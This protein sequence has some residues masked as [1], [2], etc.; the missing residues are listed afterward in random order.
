MDFMYYK[1]GIYHSLPAA[2]WIMDKEDKPVGEFFLKKGMDQGR[3]LGSLLRMGRRKWREVLALV[4]QLG[5]R[6]LEIF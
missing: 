1:S 3:S 5:R 2:K 4:K 6:Y